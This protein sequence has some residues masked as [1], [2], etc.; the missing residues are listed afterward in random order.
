MRGM[1]WYLSI[2][3]KLHLIFFILVSYMLADLIILY[4]RPYMLATP[5]KLGSPNPP[6]MTSSASYAKF[7]SIVNKNIFSLTGDIPDTLA[8]LKSNDP[9]AGGSGKDN[10]PVPSTLPINLIGT[11]V[12]SNPQ[13]SL[14]NIEI[15]SKNL[16]IAVRTGN[17]IDTLAKLESVERG[18]IIIRNLNN[19]RL[20]YLELKE[21][22]KLSFN[23]SKNAAS[24]TDIKQ[25]APNKYE[26]KKSDVLKYT[27]DL[28]NVLQQAAMVPARGPGG[29]ILGFRFVNIQADSIYTKL[30]FQVGDMI[31]KVNGEPIDSPAKAL[32]LYGA[33]K[34]NNKISITSERDGREQTTDY[35]IK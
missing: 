9:S 2:S 21:A 16:A 19:N 7:Q 29:E 31:K 20:E 25:V 11:L 28:S 8:S 26:I 30:G 3:K 15:K 1:K 5:I 17:T 4:I 24:D 33:L 18:K 34:N 6:V 13:K 35:D 14:A 10:V 27:A 12:H 23:A 32:E 22:S